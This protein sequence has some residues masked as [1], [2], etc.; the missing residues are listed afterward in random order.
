MGEYLSKE[1]E[2]P[3]CNDVIAELCALATTDALSRD[4]WLL[5]E[6]HVRV[7]PQCASL[8]ADCKSLT[9]KGMAKLGAVRQARGEEGDAY[10]DVDGWDGERAKLR[11]LSNPI[12]TG[13]GAS[14][15]PSRLKHAGILAAIMQALRPPM[16]VRVAAAFL[17]AI[18]LA[19][20]FGIR[21]GVERI[22]ASLGSTTDREIL[23]RQQLAEIETQRASL[24]AKLVSNATTT[25]QFEERLKRAEEER[26][27]F[28]TLYS[29]AEGKAEDLTTQSQRQSQT[30]ADVSLERQT[31]Q[32]KLAEQENV[33]ASVRKDLG[34]S[35]DERKRLLLSS[36]NLEAQIAQLS[37]D[38]HDREQSSQRQQQ[39]LASDRDVRE[40]MGARQLYI[41][42]V[43]DVDSQGKTRKPFGRVF[44]TRG[45]SLIF[46][47]FDLDKEPGYREAKAF[48]AWGRPGSSQTTPVSLGIFYMDNESNRRWALKFDD[49][50][51]LDEINAV[52]VTVEPKGGSKKPTNK[53][54]LLAYLH[55][56]PPNHP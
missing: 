53:P 7:C 41:A 27:H 28:Q 33:L 3:E 35:E 11:L 56:A 48:Q 8:L 17:V 46:Y 12:V 18:L 44:Y 2:C 24:D 23:L 50:K 51:V 55:T 10:R 30:I 5:V 43:F 32:Q 19:Y 40:L 14:S 49:P 20:Q 47:A 52:F 39:F 26:A 29:D 25:R 9:S 1:P 13:A 15:R 37:I 45:K 42:D 6:A 38:L 34:T 54:F 4:E 16:F 21:R 22:S 31:L 36:A